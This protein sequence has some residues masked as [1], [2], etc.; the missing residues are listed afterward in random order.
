MSV[1][2]FFTYCNKYNFLTPPYLLCPNR[3]LYKVWVTTGETVD[4][5]RRGWEREVCL[6]LDEHGVNNGRT[7]SVRSVLLLFLSLVTF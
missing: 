1:F 4:R 7:V 2:V 3:Y 5:R 6:T